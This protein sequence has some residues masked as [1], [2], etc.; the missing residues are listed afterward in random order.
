[1]KKNKN[2]IIK[3]TKYQCYNKFPTKNLMVIIYSIVLKMK[4]S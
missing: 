3:N 4:K 2:I 1:M